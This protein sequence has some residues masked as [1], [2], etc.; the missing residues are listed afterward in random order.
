VA[1]VGSYNDSRVTA[2]ALARRLRRQA[3]DH[4]EQPDQDRK[5]D[6]RERDGSCAERPHRF[7]SFETDP[8]AHD[9]PAPYGKSRPPIA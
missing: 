5:S 8:G 6:E 4:G 3:E 2:I 9:Q 1:T 7:T